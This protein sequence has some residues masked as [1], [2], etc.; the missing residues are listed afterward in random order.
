MRV[1]PE[2]DQATERKATGRRSCSAVGSNGGHAPAGCTHS[3]VDR[4]EPEARFLQRRLQEFMRSRARHGEPGTCW[5][6]GRRSW[7]R[8]RAFPDVVRCGN[9]SP[10]APGVAV[11][12]LEKAPAIAAGEKLDPFD[13]KVCLSRGGANP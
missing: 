13:P 4:I 12:W 3:T 9:C 7:W 8:S 2:N 11:E 10:P 5:W 1:D 6:C